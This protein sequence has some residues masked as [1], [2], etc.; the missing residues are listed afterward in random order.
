MHLGNLSHTPHRSQPSFFFLPLFAATKSH[1]YF[2]FLAPKRLFIES[3]AMKSPQETQAVQ[4]SKG[5]DHFR[6]EVEIKD[7]STDVEPQGGYDGDEDQLARLGKKQVLKV[8]G[9]IRA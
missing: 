9:F 5:A 6:S 1:S 2:S 8:C 4:D 3:G 7:S